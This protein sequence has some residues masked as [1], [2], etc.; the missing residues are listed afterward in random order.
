MTTPPSRQ[1]PS[2]PSPPSAFGTT[3]SSTKDNPRASSTRS[4]ATES[5]SSTISATIRPRPSITI[6]SLHTRLATGA[7]SPSPTTRSRIWA[8]VPRWACSMQVAMVR[9]F[10]FD[11][12]IAADWLTRLSPPGRSS[13]CAAVFFQS[14]RC[15]AWSDVD[16][17]HA[18]RNPECGFRL[19]L[20]RSLQAP[21]PLEA[22]FFW[23]AGYISRQGLVLFG[24]KSSRHPS[25]YGVALFWHSTRVI[26]LIWM[27]FF[28]AGSSRRRTRT[29]RH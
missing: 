21:G 13:N 10:W 27:F 23:L 24:G 16:F 7:S 6:S 9:I 28:G 11:W 8:I 12:H 22:F 18:C 4:T 15:Y 14:A 19:D 1:Q 2:P 5:R 20:L 17:R 26:L 25:R 29:A 3:Q